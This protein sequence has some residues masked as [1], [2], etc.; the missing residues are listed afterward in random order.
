MW[1]FE[2]GDVRGRTEREGSLK[3]RE[4]GVRSVSGRR[5]EVKNAGTDLVRK[6]WE[7][8][9]CLKGESLV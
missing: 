3:G 1:S 5:Q 9:C 2:S 7:R 8:R 4:V 6:K